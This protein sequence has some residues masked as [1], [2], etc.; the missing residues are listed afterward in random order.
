MLSVHIRS[1]LHADVYMK[2]PEGLE[3]LPG[4]VLQLNTSLYGLKQSGREWYI[5]ACHSL[6]SIGLWPTASDPSVFTLED[7]SLVLWLY[8][9]NML[10]LS[11]NS[12][13]IEQVISS[14]RKLWDIKDMGEVEKI[15]GLRIQRDRTHHALTICQT[16]YIEETLEKFDLINAKSSSLPASDRNML[17]AASPNEPQADQSLYQQAIGRLTWIANSTRFDIFYAVGQ[18]GQHCNKL[19]IRHWNSILQVLRYL[20]G[21]WDLKIQLRG[22]T[23]TDRMLHR[24]KRYGHKLHG[25]SDADYAGDHVDRRSVSDH[26][27]M[28]NRGLIGWSSTKQ[29]CIVTSTTE[30]E[31]I[32]L[33]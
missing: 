17:I 31:Y 27:Y 15:L 13:R 32:A 19:V 16:P 8:V 23:Q 1:K 2:P 20:S 25:F 10:V 26:L 28:L 4:K 29:R 33:S 21:T 22:T 5:E 7:K 11:N 18:L 14:I 24:N 6:Q 30:A 9:N 3:C 12:K